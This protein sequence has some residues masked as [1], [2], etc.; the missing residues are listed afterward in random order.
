MAIANGHP[1]VLAVEWEAIDQGFVVCH[2]VAEVV[3]V[4]ADPVHPRAAE[5]DG[6]T[7]TEDRCLLTAVIGE[8]RD[9]RL[10]L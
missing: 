5:V 9:Q 4:L 8:L 3:D 6:L 1:L 7:N 10:P 2:A